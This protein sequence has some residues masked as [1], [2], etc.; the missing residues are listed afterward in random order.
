[1]APAIRSRPGSCPASRRRSRG[2]SAI[3]FRVGQALRILP[4]IGLA[5]ILTACNRS[6]GPGAPGPAAG[7]AVPVEVATKSGAAMVY[8]PAGDFMMGSALGDPDEAP[9]HKVSVGAFL[10]DK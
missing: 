6:T 5:A 7:V 8:I 4:L 9:A 1:M 3:R 2:L 10:I